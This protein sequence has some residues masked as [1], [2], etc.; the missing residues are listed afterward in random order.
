MGE[1]GGVDD[2]MEGGK[3][4]G[5]GGGVLRDLSLVWKDDSLPTLT[6]MGDRFEPDFEG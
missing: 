1:G 2:G 4:G 5:G 3:R 6:S